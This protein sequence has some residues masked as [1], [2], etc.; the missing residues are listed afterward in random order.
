MAA[1]KATDPQAQ[2]EP[3]RVLVPFAYA[4]TAS[5]VV[6]QLARGDV[7]DTAKFDE[8]S[9]GHLRSIGFIG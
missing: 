1:K 3:I 7:V 9:M 6:V 2:P 8:G 4:R 5:G